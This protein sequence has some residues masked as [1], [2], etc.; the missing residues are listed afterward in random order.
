MEKL[1]LPTGSSLTFIPSDLCRETSATAPSSLSDPQIYWFIYLFWMRHI[2]LCFPSRYFRNKG[3]STCEVQR[4]E[5]H[6]GSKEAEGRACG[7]AHADSLRQS[8]QK[9]THA[10]FLFLFFPFLHLPW[11]ALNFWA[12]LPVR[13]QPCSGSA[14][15]AA[16]F[17]QLASAAVLCTFPAN[18]G[19]VTIWLRLV[20]GSKKRKKKS[21]TSVRID[22]RLKSRTH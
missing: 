14:R 19:A 15:Q 1:Q 8:P 12:R 5:W 9:H 6:G 7:G 11:L 22:E 13:Q 18:D 3:G 20:V 4:R 21:G 16:T 10:S 2:V 17:A